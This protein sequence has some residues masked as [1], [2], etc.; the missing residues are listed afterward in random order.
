MRSLAV[1]SSYGEL[2]LCLRQRAEALG[3][4]NMTLD[5]AAGLTSGHAGKLLSSRPHRALGPI[6]LGL[7]LEA[8]GLRLV[9]VEDEEALARMRPRLHPRKRNGAHRRIEV[10]GQAGVV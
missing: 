8:L 6:S 7:M 2:I 3:V 4:S 5:E 10:V 1:V 9:V